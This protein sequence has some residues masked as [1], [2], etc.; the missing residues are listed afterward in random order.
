MSPVRRLLLLLIA[1]VLLAAGGA[2]LY[3]RQTGLSALPL[4]PPAEA[5]IAR[6]LRAVAVP[7]EVRARL[8]PVPA[9][10]EVLAEGLAHFADHC[11]S[12]H[13]IDGSGNTA[14]GRGLYP[15]AP[16]MRAEATQRLTDGELFWIIEQGV[17]FTGMPGWSTGTADGERASWMLVRAIRHLPKLT[18]DERTRL[19]DLVPRSPAEVRQEIE[20]ERFLAGGD[21]GAN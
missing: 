1:L 16:D 11:A 19:E 10:P 8:N 6:A 21:A 12:C 3:I 4:P 5:R 20:E 13:A 7:A 14:L 18:T 2:L 9:T 17:R 15:K